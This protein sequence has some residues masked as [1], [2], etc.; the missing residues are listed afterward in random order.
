MTKYPK[1]NV[2]VVSL[3]LFAVAAIA[4]PS[5]TGIEQ[6][7]NGSFDQWE[8]DKPV[9]WTIVSGATEGGGAESS[10]QPG[11]DR[12]DGKYSLL[13]S[14]DTS[15]QKWYAAVQMI[16]VTPG[17]VF[18]FS[19]WLH[20][21]DISRDGHKY[22]N[23]QVAITAK[24]EDGQKVNTW[25]LG[26]A[27]G[28][29]EWTPHDIYI[30]VPLGSTTFEV[31]VFL[32]MSGTLECDDLSLKKLQLPA[33]DPNASRDEKW[34]S[35][36]AYLSELL[37]KLHVN[38]FTMISETKF[39]S[40]AKELEQDVGKLSDLQIN[41]QL[42]ALV[43]SLGDAHSGVGFAKRPQRLPIQFKFFD[44]D[45][46][47]LAVDQKCA[48][49]AG[50]KV[51]RV[52]KYSLEECL[53]KV[54]PLIA[55]ETESWFRNMAP[56]VLGLADVYY[57][58]GFTNSI[59]QVEISVIGEDG[60]ETSCVV[61]SPRSDEK[62]Q[63]ET[64]D[65][66]DDKRPLHLSNNAHY[67]YN[68][69]EEERTFYLQYNRCREDS[70]NPM[71]EFTEEVAT[72]LDEHEINK[73]VLDL[74][75][76][77]GGG[78]GLLN[79]LIGVVAERHTAGKINQCFVITGCAT[80]SA[81]ALNTLDFRG[82]TGALVVGEPMGN[83]PN[84]FGQLNYFVLPNTGMRVQYATKHFIRMDGDPPVLEP[85]IPVRASWED[86]MAGRDPVLEQVLGHE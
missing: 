1:L 62:L 59:G 48:G 34:R 4:A 49:L 27:S 41:L 74:R 43:S 16:D 82:A 21:V 22:G 76:N 6:L 55:C 20:S 17:D 12:G 26:P 32:S 42:M 19:G 44:D 33:A 11:L 24:T 83:K 57:G 28:T 61:K 84:R 30:Q 80:F 9:S 85:D 29:T 58:L 53:N 14:G 25:I 38:P 65:P 46:R 67:W 15:T 75:H 63:Y 78:S 54:R 64:R 72:F 31:S 36:V 10:V 79:P 45:L 70:Q 51:T 56:Q 69:I 7:E 2:F 66:A 52:G 39:L 37:P 35:D 5:P 73:F 47:V 13:M 77:S 71:K 8:N 81:A 60:E 50:G 86:Y 40:Q 3:L 18:H 23:S 68:Y